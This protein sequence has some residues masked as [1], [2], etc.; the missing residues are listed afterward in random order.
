M[1]HASRGPQLSLT[2]N[3]PQKPC[4]SGSRK[5]VCQAVVTSSAN[6]YVPGEPVL[7]HRMAHGTFIWGHTGYSLQE[8][9]SRHEPKGSVMNGSTY[10][11][12]NSV[13][14]AVQFQVEKKQYEVFN[15]PDIQLAVQTRSRVLQ[16]RAFDG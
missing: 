12:W 5:L 13:C 9:D 16:H 1:R 14:K 10:F 3:G 7:L 11:P 6:G 4:T 8:K 15:N 2:T